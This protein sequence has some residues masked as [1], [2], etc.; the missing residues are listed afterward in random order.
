MKKKIVGLIQLIHKDTTKEGE[1]K[2]L[3]IS[4]RL[5]ILSI[6]AYLF[7]LFI[8]IHTSLFPELQNVP[9][10]LTLI[11]CMILYVFVFYSTYKF[12]SQI[13]FYLLAAIM[14]VWIL[15]FNIMLGW[16]GGVQLFLF[17]LIIICYCASYD[18]Y[19]AKALFTVVMALFRLGLFTY[20]KEHDPIVQLTTWDVSVLQIINTAVTFL[21][22]GII[23][24]YFS[25]STQA[26]EK[27]LF[28]YNQKLENEVATDPLT[29]LLNRRK[30][31]WCLEENIRKWSFHHNGRK[32][33]LVM[34]DID[35]FKKINDTWGH[36]CG[37][38]ILKELSLIFMRFMKGK[39]EI[40]RWGGEEFLF[41]F[42]NKN[43]RE[44][45]DEIQK[46]IEEIRKYEFQYGEDIIHI[47]V[48]FGLQEYSP[49]LGINQ[50]IKA[51]DE[52]LYIGKQSGRD[53]L[54]S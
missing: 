12:D 1:S 3:L 2:N 36:E 4:L 23:C 40:A 29:R 22:M 42:E 25:A 43:Q 6:L 47:T 27:K 39:G 18:N 13:S 51:A 7:L 41:L 28:L 17:P 44:T 35:F 20:C 31:I 8:L 45:A 50:T 38:L 53:C 15:L 5:I 48:T 52:K 24:W 49:A 9:V 54:V 10:I 33:S 46:L 30:M 26:T 34:G 16:D 11:V 32:F 37:D 19:R 14:I 21:C